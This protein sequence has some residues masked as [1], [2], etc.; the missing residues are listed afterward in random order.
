MRCA[1]P[2]YA[3]M[4][5]LFQSA[6]AP[7]AFTT[8]PHFAS[9]ALIYALNASGVLPT[10]SAPALVNTVLTSADSSARRSSLLRCMT[11]ARGVPAGASTPVHDVDSA[12]GNPASA[13]VGTSGATDTRVAVV[14]A[15]ALT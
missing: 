12:P 10:G 3:P 6:F 11:I 5:V 2:G 7:V 13:M 9:S 4:V 1:P 15:S 8:L 14:T